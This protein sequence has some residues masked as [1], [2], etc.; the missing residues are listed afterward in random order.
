LWLDCCS[1]REIAEIVGHEFTSFADVT[2]QTIS[3][4]VNKFSANADFLSPP[5]AKG[6]V[7]RADKPDF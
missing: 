4:W 7:P 5:G 3:N 2:Q 6:V 1:Q